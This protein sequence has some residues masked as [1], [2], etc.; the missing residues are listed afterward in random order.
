MVKIKEQQK[1]N[2]A[3]RYLD[4]GYNVKQNVVK[5]NV[6][7]SISHE[8]AKCKKTYELIKEGKSVVT[9]AI[10]KGGGRADIFCLNDFRV[11]EVLTSETEKEFLKKTAKYPNGLDIIYIKSGEVL[12]WN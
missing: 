7:N 2:K 5:L 9:E 3:L 8:L 10:F 11:F 4:M 6:T 1:I 12:K